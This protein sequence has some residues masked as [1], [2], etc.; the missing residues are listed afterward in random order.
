MCIKDEVSIFDS[1]NGNSSHSEK[2]IIKSISVKVDKLGTLLGEHSTAIAVNETKIG[3]LKTMFYSMG[4]L[5][6]M[7]VAMVTMFK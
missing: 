1:Q 4:G 3:N 2:D 6:V 5:I 7:I